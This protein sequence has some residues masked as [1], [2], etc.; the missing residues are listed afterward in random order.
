MHIVDFAVQAFFSR[1]GLST[2]LTRYLLYLP[3]ELAM[4]GVGGSS[5][6]FQLPF[7]YRSLRGSEV[8]LDASK[9]ILFWGDFLHSRHYRSS[10]ARILVR[11]LIAA[12]VREGEDLVDKYLFFRDLPDS[13]LEKTI[14]FGEC[15]L[16]DDGA[17]QADDA[18]DALLQRLVNKAAAIWTRDISSAMRVAHIKGD[19]RTSHAGIDCALLMRRDDYDPLGSGIGKNGTVGCFFGRTR[20]NPVT[21]MRLAKGL[22]AR[23]GRRLSWIP[24]FE[25]PGYGPDLLLRYCDEADVRYGNASLE[26]SIARLRIVDY[27]VTDVYHLC[28]QAWNLGIPAVCVGS[29]VSRFR[30]SISEKKKEIFHMMYGA[31]R[32]FVPAEFLD[33]VLDGDVPPD[34]VRLDEAWPTLNEIVRDLENRPSTSAV[35]TRIARH[36]AAI[37]LQLMS[38]IGGIL[39]RHALRSAD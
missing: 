10:V 37:E 7:S 34:D 28:V 33:R 35:T 22:S 27:V 21:M 39:D 4:A 9:I 11:S 15:L 14:L 18:Y 30:T 26:S 17:A 3:E 20:G 36:R 6:N 13:I 12:D 31:E 5:D 24:W 23:L 29:V 2:D 16:P 1:H 25:S 38:A 32:F 19:Y 8:E